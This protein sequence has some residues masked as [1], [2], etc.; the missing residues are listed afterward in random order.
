[1]VTD[2]GQ[3]GFGNVWF[4]LDDGS[5]KDGVPTPVRVW[6]LV[7]DGSVVSPG[8]NQ[9]WSVVGAV[10]LEYDSGNNRYNRYNRTLLAD[11]ARKVQ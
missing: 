9:Y 8:L 6:D 5:T 2:F 4:V 7:G 11:S 1:M 3:D 10:G